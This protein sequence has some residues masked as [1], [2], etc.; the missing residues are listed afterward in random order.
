[1]GAQGPQGARGPTGASGLRGAQG[2][3]GA[4]GISGFDLLQFSSFI[5]ELAVLSNTHSTSQKIQCD[6]VCDDP[7][8]GVIADC[9]GLECAE[10][11]RC[12]CSRLGVAGSPDERAELTAVSEPSMA[13][14]SCEFRMQSP[15][16]IVA[17]ASVGFMGE[18]E[19]CH[20]TQTLVG[21]EYPGEVVESASTLCPVTPG[22]YP[23]TL[24]PEV[25][26]N[27]L[28]GVPA[29]EETQTI[30]ESFE[31]EWL[32]NA[33]GG[34][35]GRFYHNDRA[36]PVTPNFVTPNPRIE[37]DSGSPSAVQVRY[38]PCSAFFY[39]DTRL[40]NGLANGQSTFNVGEYVNDA[41]NDPLEI[42][43]N[44]ALPPSAPDSFHDFERDTGDLFIGYFHRERVFESSVW[45]ASEYLGARILFP[46][47]G[48]GAAADEPEPY[49]RLAVEARESSEVTSDPIA[50]ERGHRYRFEGT[51]DPASMTYRATVYH[52][53]LDP[54]SGSYT[55]GAVVDTATI[56]FDGSPADGGLTELT[57]DDQFAWNE[58]RPWALS[59]T[60]N[61]N[62][63]TIRELKV[64]SFGVYHE[65]WTER[66]SDLIDGIELNQ[67]GQPE[68]VDQRCWNPVYREA[69]VATEE[70][71]E[72]GDF[73]GLAPNE[74]ALLKKREEQKRAPLSTNTPQLTF[75]STYL[76]GFMQTLTFFTGP[77]QP[78]SS[79]STNAPFSTT[80][81][82]GRSVNPY[83]IGTPLTATYTLPDLT[84]EVCPA[85]QCPVDSSPIPLTP[86]GGA[87]GTSE[88]VDSVCG[89]VPLE[90]T[91]CS[92]QTFQLGNG[93]SGFL[94]NTAGLFP[95]GDTNTCGNWTL[96]ASTD[97]INFEAV[98]GCNEV[99]CGDDPLDPSTCSA[100]L[101]DIRCIRYT[102]C[103]P[104]D[105]LIQLP[106]GRKRQL[107]GIAAS[108]VSCCGSL[109]AREIEYAVGTSAVADLII[110]EMSYTIPPTRGYPA[111]DDVIVVAT[112]A[113]EV[114]SVEADGAGDVAA[115]AENPFDVFFSHAA[116]TTVGCATCEGVASDAPYDGLNFT[117][118]EDELALLGYSTPATFSTV[119]SDYGADL[120]IVTTD[121]F[122][123][124]QALACAVGV[125]PQQLYMYESTCAKAGTSSY[126]T[127]VMVPPTANHTVFDC[128]MGALAGGDINLYEVNGGVLGEGNVSDA[129]AACRG[130]EAAA[131][132]ASP[133]ANSTCSVGCAVDTGCRC[134]ELCGC[135][136]D[137]PRWKVWNE[138]DSKLEDKAGNDCWLINGAYP[139]ILEVGAGYDCVAFAEGASAL[140]T[141]SLDT[142]EADCFTEI[143]DGGACSIL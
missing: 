143:Q 133:L 132:C 16:G 60:N 88:L 105:L 1:M 124:R 140:G 99:L 4:T 80:T 38:W 137:D 27:V 10:N 142:T 96:E 49:L 12:R 8:G 75:P 101:E 128:V 74:D 134:A 40:G 107:V 70:Q 47:E 90:G 102:I 135:S 20:V 85:N 114:Y 11:T 46:A 31:S 54:V 83:T 110:D 106:P 81:T 86:L 84:L 92:E 121:C 28:N 119:S 136:V 33:V 97:C 77:T 22:G 50:L 130:E 94:I 13:G 109:A 61:T 39:A 42:A 7:C 78:P 6:S 82:F 67:T 120:D 30:V 68:G 95:S 19:E 53:T 41:T 71:Q 87:A 52:I 103:Q 126:E 23:K 24:T 69:Q 113:G 139:D 91:E 3:T 116:A 138:G 14:L 56:V 89:P 62:V 123:V 100:T 36:Q 141:V 34:W 76:T 45:Y 58:Q 112:C 108:E 115:D 111:E 25:V 66:T 79:T 2:A 118:L 51:F 21:G 5:D 93:D 15:A 98:P 63:L 9:G 104:A 48:N 129:V 117:A 72:F 18:P 43:F 44:F 59:E 125:A 127:K 17:Q 65:D 37:L 32:A 122:N 35:E 29:C 26:L 55:L 131:E 64:N 57:L 73:V